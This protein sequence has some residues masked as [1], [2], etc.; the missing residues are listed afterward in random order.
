M[1]IVTFTLS[2]DGVIAL[3]NALACI[4]KFC[5]DVCLDASKDKFVLTGLNLTKSAHIS[6]SFALARFFS[7]YSFQGS[8]Q[9]RERFHCSIYIKALLAVF[10][11]RVGGEPGRDREREA[12]IERCDVAIDD[13]PGKKSRFIAQ[14]VCR[15]GITATHSL[16]FEVKAPTRVRFD[17]DEVVN[18]WTIESRTLRQLMEHFGPGI[19]LLDINTEGEN[20]VNFAC[21]TEKDFKLSS[22]A[23]ILKKPLH[24]SIAVEMDEFDDIAIEAKLHTIIPVKD[25]R[26]IL[27]HATITSAT[28]SA[29]YSNPAR[30]MKLHYSADGILCEFILMTVGERGQGVQKSRRGQSAA[31]AAKPTLDAGSSRAGSVARAR[32]QRAQESAAPAAVPLVAKASQP[33][34]PSA[35]DMRPPPLPPPSTMRSEAMFVAQDD[36]QQWE[37]VNEDA[38]EDDDDNGPLGWDATND[39]GPPTMR[40]SEHL[41]RTASFEARSEA[42]QNDGLPSEVEPTQ[43]LSDVRRF[44]LFS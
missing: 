27:Q 9:Y 3:Q 10:R 2:E 33:P 34:R 26:A 14:I 42:P 31:K 21:Y 4:L 39:P 17:P 32:S 44:G 6:F 29:R 12:A 36:D 23:T 13:G 15:N 19:D 5:D 7:R 41:G 11:A 38:G 40:I 18:H 28:L 35:F 20:V 25:F 24:T 37:P 30:P 22:D 1:A 8:E 16:P 43:R